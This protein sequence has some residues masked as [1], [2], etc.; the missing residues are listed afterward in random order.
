MWPHYHRPGVEFSRGDHSASGKATAEMSRANDEQ[1]S[2]RSCSREDTGGNCAA[3]DR[4]PATWRHPQWSLQS[5]KAPFRTGSGPH[6]LTLILAVA[7]QK[8]LHR[9]RSPRSQRDHGTWVRQ[10]PA[11]RFH[12]QVVDTTGDVWLVLS[13]NFVGDTQDWRIKG[14]TS[15]TGV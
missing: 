4:I 13:E 5:T 9:H 6:P 3:R 11:T 15:T 14:S 8:S 1:G 7:P 12:R 10:L 2:S